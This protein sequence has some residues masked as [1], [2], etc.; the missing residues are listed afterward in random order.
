MSEGKDTEETV[1]DFGHTF[2]DIV[3]IKE[4]F[5]HVI[6]PI[7]GDGSSLYSLK[8]TRTTAS[9]SGSGEVNIQRIEILPSAS[10]DNAT[11]KGKIRFTK[12]QVKAIHTAMY[13]GLSLIIGPAGTGK[14]DVAV[15]IIRNLYHS[16][17]SQ[18][19]VIVTQSNAALNDIFAKIVALQEEDSN[20]KKIDMRHLLR[21]GSGER[22]LR[23]HLTTSSTNFSSTSSEEEIFSKQGRVNYCLSR[24]LHLLNEV[25]KLA[26]SLNLHGDFGSSC[27]TAA[28]F[29][30]MQV[31]PRL[32]HFQER[33][34]EFP[35]AAYF[36]QHEIVRDEDKVEK[37]N[38]IFE[39]LADYRAL[40]L[41]R[42]PALRGDYLLTK[43]ESFPP[44][45]S[46]CCASVIGDAMRIQTIIF[47]IPLVGA[48][49]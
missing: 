24:R 4:S 21:L 14:T 41:L 43:Q 49:P 6:A 26:F 27:E 8:L 42:T 31:K 34:G 17:P 37:V 3:H 1:I 22:D 25:Q 33:K 47:L 29:Y 16:F 39:E 2:L 20:K 28:Y 5:P 12:A 11:T 18:R 35:F 48:N 10:R 15:Q 13:P 44:H 40:E 32:Q 45:L 23:D 30:T 46:S 9:N 19:I 36:Q 38:V 7:E